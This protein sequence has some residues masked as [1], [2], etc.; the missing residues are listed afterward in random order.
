MVEFHA[1]RSRVRQRRRCPDCHAKLSRGKPEKQFFQR[2]EDDSFFSAMVM[3][4]VGGFGFLTYHL[5]RAL[6]PKR[7]VQRCAHCGYQES[8]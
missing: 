4:L 3:Y 5:V 2:R 8:R 7:F 6:Q 1:G